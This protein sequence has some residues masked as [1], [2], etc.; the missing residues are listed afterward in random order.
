[1]WYYTPPTLRDRLTFLADPP[2]AAR[3]I[4]TDTIDTV[5]LEM[6]RMAPMSVIPY[7]DFT[8]TQHSFVVYAL[9]SGPVLDELRS[10]GGT[11]EEI[12]SE[13]G[14]RVYHVRLGR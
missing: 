13:A 6:R 11:I 1:M 12:G 8:S 10:A 5:L 7:A 2:A 9:G 3:A 14:A 4:G